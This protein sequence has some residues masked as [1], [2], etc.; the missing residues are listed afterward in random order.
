MNP[1]WQKNR[2]QRVCIDGRISKEKVK[3]H[4]VPQGSILGPQLFLV[5][6]ADLQESVGQCLDLLIHGQ[7]ATMY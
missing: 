4:G 2:K 5:Y 7:H 1:Y 6:T 3:T